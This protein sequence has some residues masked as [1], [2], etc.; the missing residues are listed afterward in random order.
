MSDFLKDCTK[1]VLEKM[2]LFVFLQIAWMVEFHILAVFSAK[3]WFHGTAVENVKEPAIIIEYAQKIANWMDTYNDFIFFAGIILIIVGISGAFFKLIPVLNKYKIIYTYSDFG[4]YAGCWL[5][6]I[7]YTYIIY[8]YMG[9]WFL[10]APIIA[11]IIYL[12]I[13]TINEKLEKKG[14]TFS[15][16]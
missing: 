7:D 15:R 4:F 6:L 8:L 3:D 10:L 5:L 11:Y 9:K 16:N 12:I 13:R 2:N 1:S 14:I